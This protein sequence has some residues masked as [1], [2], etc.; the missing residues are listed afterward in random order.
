MAWVEQMQSVNW[1][2]MAVYALG[3][4]VLGCFATGYYLVRALRGRDIRNVDSGS[5]GARNVSQVLGKSGF[6]L[7]TL[8]DIAKGVLAVWATLHLTGDDHLAALVMVAVTVGH[9]W[10]V[11]LCFRGGKGV[12]TSL[13][14]LL[15]YD[16][17]LA[18]TYV[19]IFLGGFVFT[20]KTILPG[21][22]GYV[23]LPVAAFWLDHD[24][25]QTGVITLLGAII[26]V[27]HRRNIVEEFPALAARCGVT[28][29]PEQPKL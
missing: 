9:V 10:P 29:K 3:A 22:F 14:A 17:R 19:V 21:L 18:V 23:C 11:Q 15:V 5:V 24:A 16:W 20:R 8:G 26:L 25:L 12:A 1:G 4:Y 27:A 13:G 7:T 28:A 6:V 2:Q